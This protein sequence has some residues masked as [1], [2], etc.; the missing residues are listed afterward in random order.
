MLT[1]TDADTAH[2]N[3]H[4]TPQ[5]LLIKYGGNAMTDPAAQSAIMAAIAQLHQAGHRIVLVHGGGPFIKA[6]LERAQIAAEFI[7]GHRV[8]TT[9]AMEEVQQALRGKVNGDLVKAARQHDL[10]AVGIS[11]KDGQLALAK[12]RHFVDPETGQP[13]DLGFVGDIIAM[14]PTLIRTL[15]H[16]NYL[17]IVS[18]VTMGADGEDYNINADMFAGH[19]AGALGVHQYWVLTDI[20]GLR[21]DKDDPDTLITQLEVGA[22]PRLE[23]TVIQGGMIPKVESCQ[24]ALREGAKACRILNGRQPELLAQCLDTQTAIGTLIHN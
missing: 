15:W 2:I 20:D 3:T 1:D 8:T 19:L 21:Q 5:T 16:T 24:I 13:A 4:S 6:N 22:I 18:P 14:D 9:E 10:P 7:G 11:G 23:G 17:P 12:K